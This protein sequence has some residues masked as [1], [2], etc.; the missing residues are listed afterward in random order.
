MQDSEEMGSMRLEIRVME[1]AVSS[2][3]T[4]NQSPDQQSVVLKVKG[5]HKLFSKNNLI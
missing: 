1:V 2:G 3:D 5:E 4:I